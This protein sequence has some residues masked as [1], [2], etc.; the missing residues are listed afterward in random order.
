MRLLCLVLAALTLA[1][2]CSKIRALK[3][4]RTTP[5]SSATTAPSVPVLPTL[6]AP[7]VQREEQATAPVQ[8]NSKAWAVSGFGSTNEDARNDALRRAVNEVRDSLK[9]SHPDLDRPLTPTY[10]TRSGIA[11]VVNE[12]TVPRDNNQQAWEV[13]LLVELKPERLADLYDLARKDRM[14]PRHHVA[15]LVLFGLCSILAVAAIY[16]RL[17]N[18]TRGYS[19]GLLRVAA[20]TMLAVALAVMIFLW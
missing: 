1:V 9:E 10:L 4:Q 2:G 18:A 20:V 14:G 12:K 17:E 8:P 16:L 3:T 13:D 5:G 19:T 11:R 6:P 7:P 15:L